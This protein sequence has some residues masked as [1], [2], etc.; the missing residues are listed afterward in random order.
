MRPEEPVTSSFTKE[1][2]GG[3]GWGWGRRDFWPCYLPHAKAAKDAKEYRGGDLIWDVEF[4][5]LDC[6]KVV[7]GEGVEAGSRG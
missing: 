4:L 2:Y 5:M 1:S 6:R 7:K 3:L